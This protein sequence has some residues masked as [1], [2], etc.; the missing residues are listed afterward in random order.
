MIFKQ[1]NFICKE[2]HACIHRYTYIVFLIIKSNNII[3]IEIKDMSYV[4]FGLSM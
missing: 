3:F 1:S 2:I 4:L